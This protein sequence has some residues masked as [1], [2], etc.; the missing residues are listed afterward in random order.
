MLCSLNTES[1]LGTL[2]SKRKVDIERFSYDTVSAQYSQAVKKGDRKAADK[3]RARLLSHFF[4]D[5][6]RPGQPQRIEGRAHLNDGKYQPGKLSAT[7][8]W[9]VEPRYLMV[10]ANVVDASFD[11]KSPKDEPWY[12]TCVELFVSPAG[13]DGTVNQFF[14]IPA[15]VN[16]KAKVESGY[17]TP[18]AQAVRASWK[19]TARGYSVEARIPWSALKG[20]K[21]GWTRMPVDAQINSELPGGWEQMTMN[22]PGPTSDSAANYAL[23]VRK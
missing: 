14:V 13:A 16:G 19:R 21:K 11:T 3:A 4:K 20:Y 5:V 18:G 17:Q 8:V 2:V 1:P 10:N 15:G 23:L 12:G 9:R 7:F 6:I 22:K